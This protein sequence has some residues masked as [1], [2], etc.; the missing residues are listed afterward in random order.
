[1]ALE[2]PLSDDYREMLALFAKHHARYLVIGAFAVMRYTEPRYTKDIDLWA[3]ASPENAKRVFRALTD[4]G[5]PLKGLTYK[6]FSRPYGGFQNRSR[7]RAHR[8]IGPRGWCS[9]FQGVGKADDYP[10]GRP[11]DPLH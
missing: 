3:E 2:L 8:H 4:F 9:V 6:D 10:W 1:M 7:T 5:A 11:V